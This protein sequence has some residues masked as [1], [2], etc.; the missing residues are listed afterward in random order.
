M[1]T[2]YRF[3]TLSGNMVACEEADGGGT[4]VDD[5]LATGTGDLQV[6]RAYDLNGDQTSWEIIA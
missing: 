3:V 5:L 1:P 6:F 4:A 2:E